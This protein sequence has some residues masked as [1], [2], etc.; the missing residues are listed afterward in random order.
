MKDTYQLY[1]S[2]LRH[3][4]TTISDLQAD[5]E[6]MFADIELARRDYLALVTKHEAVIKGHNETVIQ[7]EYRH[8]ALVGLG[9]TLE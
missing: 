9:R 8:P 3:V 2:T 6:R 1:Q 7:S 4:D 5:K